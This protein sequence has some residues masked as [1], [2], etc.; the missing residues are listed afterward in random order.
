MTVPSALLSLLLAYCTAGALLGLAMLLAPWWPVRLW[1][2]AVVAGA[3]V[4]AWAGRRILGG[5][6]A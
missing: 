3:A 2:G 4:T 6:W 1:G 5:G